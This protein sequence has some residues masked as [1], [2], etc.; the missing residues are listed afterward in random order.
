M[1]MKKIGL[2][3]WLK[4]SAAAIMLAVGAITVS[5]QV[6]DYKIDP[7]HTE[8]D[9]AIKHMAISTVHGSFHGVSGMVRFDPGDPTKWAVEA[10]IDVSTVDTGVA[11]RDNHLKSD[12]FFNVAKFPTMTFKSTGVSKAGD[13]YNL[14]GMLTMH[15]VTKPVV[16]AMEAPSKEQVGMDKKVHRGF[17]ATTTINRKDFGLS[18]GGALASGD[19]TIGDDVKIEIDVDG[20][21]Q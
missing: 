9:F 1:T 18:Y 16:L 5:A 12:A 14:N 7:A 15:G 4:R 2:T 13:H 3:G 19:A 8:A 17:T 6:H 21:Q 20:V 10:T 11:A